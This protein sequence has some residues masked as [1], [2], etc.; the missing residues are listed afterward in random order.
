MYSRELMTIEE[1]VKTYLLY[2]YIPP[3]RLPDWLLTGLP[4]E[5]K[6]KSY[7]TNEVISRLDELFD[8]ILEKYNY[9][10]HIIPLSGGWDSRLIL[11]CLLERLNKEEVQTV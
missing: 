7:Q 6:S 5:N 8:S 9:K 1:A 3:K 4:A 11:G 10:N 2:S